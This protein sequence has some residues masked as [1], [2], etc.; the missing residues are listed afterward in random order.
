[1]PRKLLVVQVAGLSHELAKRLTVLEFKP[2]QTVFPALT[3]PV[4]ASFRTGLPPEE[5]GILF[6]GVWDDT[7]RRPFFWDQSARHV[8]GGRI[9]DDF[10]RSGGAVAMICW[11]Q[12][13][14]EA[15][16]YIISPAPIHKHG[17]GIVSQV[18][19]Q[20]EDL[21]ERKEFP[22]HR[23]WG[24][25]ADDR[26]TQWIVDTTLEVLRQHRPG[27]CL[28]Y[29][30]TLDYNLQ[31]YGKD[32]KGLRQV[33]AHLK[34]LRESGYELIVFGDYAITP[35]GEPLYINRQLLDQGR[36][37]VRSVDGRLYPDFYR[38]TDFAVVDHQVAYLMGEKRIIQAPPG[39]WFAYPWWDNINEAPDYARH[40][41]IHNK[42]GFDPCELFLFDRRPERI[43]GSHG[44]NQSPVAFGSDAG[45][46]VSTLLEL[47]ALVRERLRGSR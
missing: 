24:P 1:M 2:L 44:E 37:K 46:E 33:D 21:I 25:F 3:C 40:I 42:P 35:A 26:S 12:S 36:L 31:R 39:R 20:P 7:L 29:L 28:T 14:G 47:S 27:L 15:A 17:G 18:Y 45:L 22:L 6:N 34:R 5:H 16:D 23:Y 4:Q 10:R 13:L 32:E 43:K 30:P 19:C 11:Q 8:K 9:W 38:S 41:D